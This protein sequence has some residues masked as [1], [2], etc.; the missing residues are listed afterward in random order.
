MPTKILWNVTLDT[1]PKSPLWLK[2]GILCWRIGVKHLYNIQC[3]LYMGGLHTHRAPVNR[4]PVMNL[5]KGRRSRAK[6]FNKGWF[7]HGL[8]KSGTM[9]A[10]YANHGSL[11]PSRQV[12]HPS[13]HI[14]DLLKGRNK[15]QVISRWEP[16]RKKSP[17][18][19]WSG[20][21]LNFS[22]DLQLSLDWTRCV[23]QILLKF[24]FCL[25]NVSGG[26]VKGDPFKESAVDGR[27]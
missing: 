12:Q 21:S 22:R 7:Y 4:S 17:P 13:R 11:L 9:R 5:K 6:L 26:S 1:L 10:K 27:R 19:I 15:I 20:I 14:L 2:A 23:C 18:V 25:Q 3:I 16:S 8:H 24:R